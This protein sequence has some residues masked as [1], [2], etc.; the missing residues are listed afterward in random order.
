MQFAIAIASLTKGEPRQRAPDGEP[1]PLPME[2]T[3][4]V[5]V[6]TTGSGAR[7]QERE[8]VRKLLVVIGTFVILFAAAVVGLVQ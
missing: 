7:A 1:A 4:L 8:E 5:A 2:P 3:A 6:R